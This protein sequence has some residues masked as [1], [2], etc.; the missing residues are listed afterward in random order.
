[1]NEA[2]ADHFQ[3]IVRGCVREDSKKIE[4][5]KTNEE[6]SDWVKR[7][8]TTAVS[9]AYELFY[10]Q[11]ACCAITGLPL[12]WRSSWSQFSLDRGNST[13]LHCYD[14]GIIQPHCRFVC[15]LFNVA[16]SDNF[17]HKEILL[18]ILSSVPS[19]YRPDVFT[20]A[21]RAAAAAELADLLARGE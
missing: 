4:G 18:R 5:F 12:D 20:D 11:R 7:V 16:G 14:T 21:T 6:K 1:M 19:H 3:E 8:I 9:S 10:A 13:Q 17:R 2:A 15:R